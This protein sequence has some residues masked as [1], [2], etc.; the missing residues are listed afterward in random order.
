M[1]RRVRSNRKQEFSEVAERRPRAPTSLH[2]P[3]QKKVD[4][5]RTG[6][7]I[8][9]LLECYLEHAGGCTRELLYTCFTLHRVDEVMHG[10]FAHDEV[11]R[12]IIHAQLLGARRQ[13]VS[14]DASGLADL[15]GMF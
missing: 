11:D 7:L 6:A 3:I 12:G 1:I 13:V 10:F 9:L 8:I 5:E 15:P 2:C 14:D 4:G